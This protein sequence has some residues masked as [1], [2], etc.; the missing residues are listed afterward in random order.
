MYF[1]CVD[2]KVVAGTRSDA[3]YDEEGNLI[4]LHTQ[5][6]AYLVRLAMRKPHLIIFSMRSSSVKMY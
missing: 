4:D 1:N 6:Q 3:V 2:V 5:Q